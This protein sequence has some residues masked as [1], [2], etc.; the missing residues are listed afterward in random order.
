MLT[1]FLA[2]VT[3]VLFILLC[4]ASW[5]IQKQDKH[6]EELK[7]KKVVLEVDLQTEKNNNVL[8]KTTISELNNEIEKIELR[9]QNTLK[10]FN[11]FKKK[12]DKE[13]YS[14]KMQN[15]KNKTDWSKATCE[16]AIELNKLISELKYEDL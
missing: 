5:Y 11:D 8:L 6:I 3:T 12:T 14:K 1:K 15:I 10:A 7:N 2:C 16:D 13:K 9:N 4:V